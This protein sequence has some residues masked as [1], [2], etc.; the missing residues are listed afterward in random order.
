MTRNGVHQ[1]FDRKSSDWNVEDFLKECD[2]EEFEHQIGIYLRS[3][4]SIANHE[5]GC[6]REQAQRLLN[7]YREESI[8]AFC[9][10][11]RN[12]WRDGNP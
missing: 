8:V 4:E 5:D 7:R 6:K 9:L 12:R 10:K 3:L 11:S 2:I 1:F